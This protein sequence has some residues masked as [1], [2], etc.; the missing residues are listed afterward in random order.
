[1]MVG[2]CVLYKVAACLYGD[3]LSTSLRVRHTRAA[4]AAHH[5][6]FDVVRCKTS[7]FA[8]CFL[9]ASFFSCWNGRLDAVFESSSLGGFNGAVN[10]WLLS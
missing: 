9:H 1:M 5:Y 10:R 2:L 4:M 6:E 7:Q 8:R 3:L